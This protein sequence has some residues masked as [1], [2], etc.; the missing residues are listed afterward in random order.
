MGGYSF[1]LP[2]HNIPNVP[3]HNVKKLDPT[4]AAANFGTFCPGTRE[5]DKD[6][7]LEIK[8]FSDIIGHNGQSL[9]K[10][11]ITKVPFCAIYFC[12]FSCY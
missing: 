7:N 2:P 3:T 11:V 8:D 12:L 5:D 9:G 6:I 10:G 4:N 1:L